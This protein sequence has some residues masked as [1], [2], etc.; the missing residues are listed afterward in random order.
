MRDR[1]ITCRWFSRHVDELVVDHELQA[2]IQHLDRCENCRTLLRRCTHLREL[3]RVDSDTALIAESPPPTVRVGQRLQRQWRTWAKAA[4]IFFV[5]GAAVVACADRHVRYG[6]TQERLSATSR[7]LVA[8]TEELEQVRLLLR[9]EPESCLITDAGSEAIMVSAGG[10]ILHRWR[11]GV[12]GGVHAAELIERPTELGG[13]SIVAVAFQTDDRGST[14]AHAGTISVFSADGDLNTPLW[15]GRIQD[16]EI[17]QDL[18]DREHRE[19]S[20]R[21]F[22]PLFLYQADIFPA[23]PG[24]EFVT[25]FQHYR[26]SQCCIR[27]YGLDGTVLFSVFHDGNVTGLAWLPESQMLICTGLNGEAN[28]EKRGMTPVRRG[29]P[30]V[31]FALKPEMNQVE[32]GWIRTVDHPGVVEPVWYLA[33]H[34]PRSALDQVAAI[35]VHADDLLVPGQE[36]LVCGLQIDTP[37]RREAVLMYFTPDGTELT[38][39]RTTGVLYD[40]MRDELPDPDLFEWLPLPPIEDMDGIDWSPGTL[41]QQE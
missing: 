14:S 38:A 19:Y 34:G 11:T 36:L 22:S 25:V 35:K 31:M 9:E 7:S 33:L 6:R 16:D 28:A 21:Q 13:D 17:P 37:E 20:G 24:P 32:P 1:S 18:R 41:N 27:I 30:S 5:V 10:R 2:V 40:R 12:G 39:M 29:H 23:N 8:T 15:V 26:D 4:A 3:L